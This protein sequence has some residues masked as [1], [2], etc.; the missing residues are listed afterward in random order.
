MTYWEKT[1]KHQAESDNLSKLIPE[2]G[3]CEE[4]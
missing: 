3:K 4:D 1:G 2:S